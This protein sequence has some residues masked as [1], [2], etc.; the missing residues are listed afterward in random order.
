V[1]QSVRKQ[2]VFSSS[3]DLHP[4]RIWLYVFDDE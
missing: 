3:V 4:L 2:E 1:T